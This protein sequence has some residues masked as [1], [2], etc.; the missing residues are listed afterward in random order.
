[1][2][3]YET[4][5][6]GGNQFKEERL[7]ITH[8]GRLIWD[9]DKFKEPIEVPVLSPEEWKEQVKQEELRADNF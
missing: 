4:L 5:A 8:E 1:M 2:D 9:V 3:L 6:T 7:P